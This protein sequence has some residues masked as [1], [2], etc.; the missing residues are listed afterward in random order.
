MMDLADFE[1]LLPDAGHEAPA[2]ARTSGRCIA[3]C[4]ALCITYSSSGIARIETFDRIGD[5]WGGFRIAHGLAAT[6]DLPAIGVAIPL[7]AIYADVIA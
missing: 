6:L 2:T 1:E 4:R 3:I 7:A 5:S